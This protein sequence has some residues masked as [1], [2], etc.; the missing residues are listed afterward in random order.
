MLKKESSDLVEVVWR[1]VVLH[2]FILSIYFSVIADN[3]M[4]CIYSP[5]FLLFNFDFPNICHVKV[6]M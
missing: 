5:Y 2:L 3:V 6:L 1:S 4:F